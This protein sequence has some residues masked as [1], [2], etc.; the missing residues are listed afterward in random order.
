[1]PAAPVD[2]DAG[3]AAARAL[4]QDRSHHGGMDA[5]AANADAVVLAAANIPT[6]TPAPPPL[7]AAVDIGEDEPHPEGLVERAALSAGGNDVPPANGQEQPPPPPRR[8]PF[9]RAYAAKMRGGLDHPP[10]IPHLADLLWSFVGAF[11]AILAVSGLDAALWGLPPAAR[12]YDVSFSSS[13]AA[14][15]AAPSAPLPLQTNNPHP[16]GALPVLVAS[17]GASA[18]L[19]FGAPESK[20]SQPRGCVG[21]HI[22]SACVGVLARLALGELGA[23]APA[24]VVAALGM[25]LALT[26]MQLTRTTHPPGG[27]T[28]LIACTA[29]GVVSPKAWYGA[30]FVLA[31]ALGSVV[32]MVCAVL[33]NNLAA[34]RAYPTYWW[35]GTGGPPKWLRRKQEQRRSAA[36]TTNKAPPAVAAANGASLPPPRP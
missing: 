3:A 35:W 13:S 18:V 24:Y 11:A 6:T 25:A 23:R 31:V 12:S 20:L 14:A 19:L 7:F 22:L 10:P 33:V 29:P 2:P 36:P 21:G 26:T 15:A 34:D 4:E 27:A 30:R 16:L 32:M 5:A 17:F 28:A 1:M 8:R 9:A